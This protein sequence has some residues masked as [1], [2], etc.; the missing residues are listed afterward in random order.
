MKTQNSLFIGL[1]P[2]RGMFVFMSFLMATLCMV[3]LFTSLGEEGQE[4]F[5][6]PLSI[7]GSTYEIRT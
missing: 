3:F 2:Y 4:V 6:E 5:A 7:Q 1:I